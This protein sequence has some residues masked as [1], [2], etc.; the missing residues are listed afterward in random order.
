MKTIFLPP[1]TFSHI[2]LLLYR[3]TYTAEVLSV[4]LDVLWC[5][6]WSADCRC[7]LPA[8]ARHPHAF[9]CSRS[10]RGV[11]AARL[12]VQ[13]E[14][15]LP[16][17]RP[18]EFDLPYCLIGPLA[19]AGFRDACVLCF[20]FLCFICQHVCLIPRGR[21]AERPRCWPGSASCLPEKEGGTYTCLTLC[22]FSDRMHE[23]RFSQ[24]LVLLTCFK[25]LSCHCCSFPPFRL[26]PS[27]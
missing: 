17:P 6:K 20:G 24:S 7:F 23:K 9:L 4:V 22:D 8:A 25:N 19:V 1:W 18:L 27:A 21:V 14:H 26:Q 11:T 2:Y 3:R 16:Q 12:T 15:L 10:R 5:L 13:G